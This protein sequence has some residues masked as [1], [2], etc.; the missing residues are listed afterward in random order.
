M[1]LRGGKQVFINQYLGK[2]GVLGDG[3]A[4]IKADSNLVPWY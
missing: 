3:Q 2:N 1:G 4:M